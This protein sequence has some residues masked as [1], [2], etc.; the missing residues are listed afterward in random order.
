MVEAPIYLVG[1]ICLVVG[2]RIYANFFL[3]KSSSLLRNS[4]TAALTMRSLL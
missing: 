2:M 1:V 3:G 4:P